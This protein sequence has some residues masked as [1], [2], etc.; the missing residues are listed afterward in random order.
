MRVTLDAPPHLPG[1]VVARLIDSVSIALRLAIVVDMLRNQRPFGTRLA[2]DTWL[3][4]L[5]SRGV[6]IEPL[7]RGIATM[8]VPGSHPSPRLRSA[9]DALNIRIDELVEITRVGY[10]SPVEVTSAIAKQVADPSAIATILQFLVNPVAAWRSANADASRRES[11]AEL[12][13]HAA[14][15]EA[16]AAR[17]EENEALRDEFRLLSEIRSL[18]VPIADF[19]PVARAALLPQLSPEARSA[20]RRI[21]ATTSRELEPIVRIGGANRTAFLGRVDTLQA[22]GLLGATSAAVHVGDGQE[23]HWLPAPPPE[24]RWTPPA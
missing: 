12:T 11:A 8:Q 16:A 4:Q 13:R 18:P 10:G 15:R 9:V 17:R 20:L 19:D 21:E 5:E 23:E 7:V 24:E 22:I 3:E 2:P 1:V 6:D 14:R